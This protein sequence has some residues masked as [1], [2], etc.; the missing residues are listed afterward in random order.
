MHDDDA[1]FLS[2]ISGAKKACQKPEFT[3]KYIF[4]QS[5]FIWL[6][7]SAI[8]SCIE[9]GGLSEVPSGFSFEKMN[10]YA[11]RLKKGCDYFL[12]SCTS[13]AFMHSLVPHEAV[14]KEG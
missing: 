14:M 3:L 9:Y 11:G 4:H 6:Y 2:R 13:L 5:F 7:P 1:N 10:G 12:G 8:P